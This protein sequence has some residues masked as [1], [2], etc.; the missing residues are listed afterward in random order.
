[1]SKNK[2]HID[3]DGWDL[4]RA[5]RENKVDIARALIER[6]DDVNAM[7][8]NGE[9]PLHIIPLIIP[10]AAQIASSAWDWTFDQANTRLQDLYETSLAIVR[11]L[12][13]NCAD[14]NASTKDGKTPLH[15]AAVYD[16]VEVA[17]VLIIHSADVNARN[18]NG[19]TP[20]H[21]AARKNSLDMAHLLIKHNAD[22][23]ARNEYGFTPLNIATV[24]DSIEVASLL[25]KYRAKTE[26]EDMIDSEPSN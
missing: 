12:I 1:M 18:E 19:G 17:H 14:V 24:Q 20:L 5:V 21:T 23:N 26:P 3:L 4:H 16:A 10:S 22:V 6:G 8:E 2:D 7:N 11:L 15:V 9:T 13:N 25:V